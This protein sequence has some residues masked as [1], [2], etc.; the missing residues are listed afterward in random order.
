MAMV[1]SR[2]TEHSN[3][4]KRCDEESGQQ[5]GEASVHRMRSGRRRKGGNRREK[6]ALAHHNGTPNSHRATS[7]PTKQT[8]TRGL[9]GVGAQCQ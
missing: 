5:V 6:E 4:M 3:G 7:E 1:Q 8:P 2:R 9:R